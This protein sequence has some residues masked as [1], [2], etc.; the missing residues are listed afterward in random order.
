MTATMSPAGRLFAAIERGD[1]AQVLELLDHSPD[2]VW[3][4]DPL[5]KTALHLAAEYD[6]EKIAGVLIDA[7]ADV[8]AEDAAGETPLQLAR[9]KGSTK[10]AALIA[11]YL[12]A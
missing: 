1:E 4:A 2:L 10:V 5:K 12:A 8:N 9:R 3:A 11:A 6:R 7:G